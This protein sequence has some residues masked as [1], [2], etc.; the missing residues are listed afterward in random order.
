MNKNKLITTNTKSVLKTSKD[1]LRTTNKILSNKHNY[2]NSINYKLKLNLENM[3]ED[4]SV[5]FSPDGNY[6]LSRQYNTKTIVVWDIY[7]SRILFE[8]NSLPTTS[9]ALFSPNGKYVILESYKTTQFFDAK[10]GEH[11]ISFKAPKLMDSTVV[12]P[13]GRYIILDNPYDK[14]LEL[15]DI[16]S[17]SIIKTFQIPNMYFVKSVAFSPCGD[18]ILI[19]GTTGA[20][21]LLDVNTGKEMRG[22][23][24]HDGLIK[25]VAFSPDGKYILSGCSKNIIKLWDINSGQEIEEFLGYR[26]GIESVAF[27]PDGKF[28]ASKSWNSIVRIWDKSNRKELQEFKMFSNTDINSLFRPDGNYI[29]IKDDLSVKLF[30]INT[31][32]A[33]I[34]LESED[35]KWISSVSFSPNGK[36]FVSC[37]KYN[38]MKLCDI[39]NKELIKLVSFEDSE[40]ICSTPDGYYN[41]SSKA[42]KYLD[43]FDESNG[44]LKVIDK[45]HSIYKEQQREKLL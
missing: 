41:C 21:K 2:L 12:S 39:N 29:A 43:F 40:W 23:E 44:I 42:Y 26:E 10:S 5:M 28:I 6:I 11:V 45:N 32:K 36:Y 34:K 35:D 37:G 17:N 25:S 9:S 8:I 1:L 22:F 31:H 38:T 33:I 3:R 24:G 13:G 20:L 27:S 14:C 18:N 19:G 7:N 4:S 30:D 15:T 16:V